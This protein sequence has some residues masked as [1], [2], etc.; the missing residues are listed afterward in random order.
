[1]VLLSMMPGPLRSLF[2]N[3]RHRPFCAINEPV[4]QGTG[5]WLTLIVLTLCAAPFAVFAQTVPVIVQQPR[6]QNVPINGTATFT[7]SI[8]GGGAN[9]RFQ[10]RH[11]GGNLPG[12]ISPTLVV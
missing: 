8:A 7:V 11:N 6:A 10:W 3:F 5:R 1:G 2:Y 12:Q 9:V 4:I